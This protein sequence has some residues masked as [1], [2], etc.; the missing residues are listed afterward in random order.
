MWCAYSDVLPENHIAPGKPQNIDEFHKVY[1]WNYPSNQDIFFI[2][3]RG[4]QRERNR[5][6]EKVLHGRVC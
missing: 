3:L 4:A 1:A 6:A 5:H 2:Q